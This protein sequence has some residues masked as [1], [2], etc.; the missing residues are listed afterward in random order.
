MKF[1]TSILNKYLSQSLSFEEYQ[2]VFLR[3]GYEVE[4]AYPLLKA[5]DFVVTKTKTCVDH[6]N[7]D[8]LSYC[9]IEHKGQDLDVVCGGSNVKSNQ[10][11]VYAPVGSKVGDVTLAQKDLRGINSNGMILSIS[12]IINI[13]RDAIEESSK[14]EIL[15]IIN[16]LQTEISVP[17][18]LEKNN[19]SGYVF[20]LSILSDRQYANNHIMLAKEIA[21]FLNIDFIIN[22]PS[23][24]SSQPAGVN[25]SNISFADENNEGSSIQ[26]SRINFIKNIKTPT[27]IRSALYV[28]KIPV[29]NTIED[30][31][32]FIYLLTGVSIYLSEAVKNISLTKNA[33]ILDENRIDTLVSS[34]CLVNW[35]NNKERE[36]DLIS[37]ASKHHVNPINIKNLNPIHGLNNARGTSY[38]LIKNSLRFLIKIL[39]RHGYIDSFTKIEGI[40]KLDERKKIKTSLSHIKAVIGFEF[41]SHRAFK[42]LD[43]LNFE[44]DPVEEDEDQLVFSV[45][46][47]RSDVTGVQDIIEEIVRAIGTD[48]FKNDATPL[49]AAKIPPTNFKEKTLQSLKNMLVKQAMFEVKNYNLIEEE[50]NELYNVFALNRTYVLKPEFSFQRNTYRKSLLA[51][52]LETYRF[53]YRQNEQSQKTLPLFEVGNIFITADETIEEGHRIHG[54]ILLDDLYKDEVLNNQTIETSLILKTL[55]EQLLTS[56]YEVDANELN[57]ETLENDQQIFN[58]YNS[59]RVV[60]QK[61]EIAKLGELHPQVLRTNKFIR[62][63]KIK[64]KLFYLEI[65]LKPLIENLEIK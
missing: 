12:E 58:P 25:A 11:V 30:V 45:P 53:N 6:P 60:Y 1:L 61:E 51:G 23:L 33:L 34:N 43:N 38:F 19:L 10:W 44:I 14:E 5:K 16:R 4:E 57:F 32:N 13:D 18:F 62:L 37:F 24:E 31:L 36:L 20:D 3:L 15:E 59:A 21:A 52:L 56:F 28:N 63:D 2:D 39:L 41:D 54:A 35:E 7:A 9:I 50:Q 8:T 49:E 48:K 42:I 26:N 22:L 46:L 27:Y 55:L 17:E 29:Q 65:N 47:Y 64:R 40:E